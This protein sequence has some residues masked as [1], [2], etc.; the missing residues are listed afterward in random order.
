LAD[1]YST[2]PHELR[3]KYDND[4]EAFGYDMKVTDIGTEVE[5][6]KMPDEVSEEVGENIKRSQ[7]VSSYAKKKREQMLKKYREK[8]VDT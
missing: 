6:E 7:G 5:E 1:K 4:L 8:G 3:E 2:P